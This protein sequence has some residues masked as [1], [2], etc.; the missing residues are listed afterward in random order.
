MVVEPFAETLS[1]LGMRKFSGLKTRKFRC[2]VDTLPLVCT[3][4]LTSRY[5]F[6]RSHGTEGRA[7]H[8]DHAQN[9]S[10]FRS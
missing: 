1:K 4:T 8:V 7:A 2:L 6:L 3:V 5:A 10:C 9:G